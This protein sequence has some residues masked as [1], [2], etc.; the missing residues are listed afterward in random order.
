MLVFL[1]FFCTL[2]VLSEGRDKLTKCVQYACRGLAWAI[3]ASSPIKSKRLTALSKTA[4]DSRKVFRMGRFLDEYV[5]IRTI[6]AS[7]TTEPS[8]KLLRCLSRLAFV[9]YWIMDS[10]TLLSK[11]QFIPGDTAKAAKR[12]AVFWFAGLV[13][14]L[15]YELYTIR[16]LFLREMAVRRLLELTVNAD[17]KDNELEA[18]KQILSIRRE[19]HTAYLGIVKNCSDMVTA[20]S[21]L[22][23]PKRIFGL[24]FN[25][26]V[27]GVGGFVAAF[28]TC[29]Q[30]Y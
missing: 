1:F 12:S 20:S 5:R 30:L 4:S 6:M 21:A 9:G 26:G 2:L 18:D 11:I 10:V 16:R 7:K 3:S 8:A 29:C 22:G 27:I 25:D 17:S 24:E 23:I 28:V 14:S 13:L 19:R 15:C